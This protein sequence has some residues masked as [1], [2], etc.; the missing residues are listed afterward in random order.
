MV[1]F[2][3][4][5]SALFDPHPR[6]LNLEQFSSVVQEVCQLPTIL[7]HP[8]FERLLGQSAAAGPAAGDGGEEAGASER[9][10]SGSSGGGY[11]DRLVQR[12]TFVQWWTSRGLVSAPP[13]RR[14][15][16]VLRPDGKQHL[17]YA[18]F[19]PLLQVWK[20]VRASAAWVP[21]GCLPLRQRRH[22]RVMPACLF[23]K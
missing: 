5:V 1:D 2:H 22:F 6:G 19:R 10:A 3:T 8:W 15:W 12:D 14:L 13:A 18:D 7:A 17:T 4:R 21:P 20:R 9:T 16:E 11:F 23:A